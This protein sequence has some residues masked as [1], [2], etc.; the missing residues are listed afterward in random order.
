MSK[1]KAEELESD[2]KAAEEELARAIKVA[3]DASADEEVTGLG[4]GS[5]APIYF[6]VKGPAR[7]PWEMYAIPHGKPLV[8][9]YF[10]IRALGEVPRLLLAEAGATYEHIAVTGGEDQADALNWRTRS[11]N[12][13]LPMMSG[14]GIPRSSPISDSNAIV[15]FLA[16]KYGMAGQT[17]VEAARIDTLYEASKDLASNKDKITSGESDA[18]QAKQPIKLAKRIEEM[19][20]DMTPAAKDDGV[21][22]YGQIH[23]LHTLMQCEEAAPG[24]VGKVNPALGAF[25]KDGASRP[26]IKQY[27][28]SA[29]RFQLTKKESGDIEGGYQYPNP[30]KRSDFILK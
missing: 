9:T 16:K 3:N 8:F 6:P 29:M 18:S 19:L 17:E 28:D 2:E 12:G 13:L 22:N 27:C 26:R 25:L 21:F 7:P 30:V 23:L 10:A 15:R 20:A 11:P 1:R 24:C 5:K 14:F 4:P